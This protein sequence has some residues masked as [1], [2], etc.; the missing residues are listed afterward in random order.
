MSCRSSYRE[1]NLKGHNETRRSSRSG[2]FYLSRLEGAI[3]RDFVPWPV[4]ETRGMLRKATTSDALAIRCLMERVPGFWQPWWSDQTTEEAIRAANGLALVWEVG[5]QILG[6]VCAHDLGFR[7]YL[8]ELVVDPSVRQ[9][10]IGRRLLIAIED[11]LRRREQRT[12]IADVWRDAAS[13]YTNL[14]WSA[15]DSILLRHRLEPQDCVARDVTP[16]AHTEVEPT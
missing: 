5:S 3:G 15:P 16:N 11:L 1:P 4:S 12:V 9:Q 2:F 6:F 8:S 10:G 14:H 13:F 7:A